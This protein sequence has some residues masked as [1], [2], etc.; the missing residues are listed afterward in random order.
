MRIA[1]MGAGA[2]GAYFG[3]RFARAG[4]NV[5]LIARAS[6][7][8]AIT[9]RG[10]LLLDSSDFAVTI[11]L[12]AVSEPSGVEGADVIL[13]CVKSSDTETAGQAMLPF[14]ATHATV[15]CLQNGVDNAQRLAPSSSA[16]Q[17]RRRCMWRRR[18]RGRV[19]SSI[20]GAAN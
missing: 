18:W 1:V 16:K 14:L 4:H 5:T 17:W 7:T 6:H 10:G 15:I 2:V 13:F 9:Q 20:T 19:M 12:K 3:G 11:P 8:D